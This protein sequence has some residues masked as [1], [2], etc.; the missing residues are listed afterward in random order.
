M[1]IV[2]AG[3]VVVGIPCGFERQRGVRAPAHAVQELHG[4][5]L[6]AHVL[7]QAPVPRLLR[8]RGRVGLTAR[9]WDRAGAGLGRGSGV[10]LVP[11]L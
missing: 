10:R 11:R 1:C 4:A 8:V 7:L 3:I 6:E 5:Y 9:D 2:M